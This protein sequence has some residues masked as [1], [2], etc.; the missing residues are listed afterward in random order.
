M[1]HIKNDKRCE[2]SCALIH[3]A[4]ISLIEKKP[5][6]EITIT[7]IQ[8]KSFVGRATFY[9]NFDSLIDVLLLESDNECRKMASDYLKLLKEP[10]HHK[11]E[12]FGIVVFFF[13]Y[14]Q[15][16]TEIVET[17]LKINR[18]DILYNSLIN[19]YD[20]LA[21]TIFP[22]VDTGSDDYKYLIAMKASIGIG[23]LTRWIAEG[24]IK[25]VDELLKILYNGFQ[26]ASTYLLNDI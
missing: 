12:E 8:E 7:D 22:E 19:A 13:N 26:T 5:F 3:D 17:L 24:K 15:K 11:D 21:D 1:Y 25:T 16:N 18:I 9:R 20:D 10:G 2:K 6:D 14:W 23:F 4:L